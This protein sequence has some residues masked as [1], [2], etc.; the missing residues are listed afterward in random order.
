M[1]SVTEQAALD[2]FLST[3]ELA[4]TD[5]T[6]EKLNNV[7]IIHP[8]QRNP[9]LLSAEEER[10][11]TSKHAANRNRLTVPRRPAWHDGMKKEELDSREKAA[12]LDWRRGLAELQERNEILM[13]PF[14]RNLE[15]WRQLWRVVERSDVVVQIVDA[16]NPLLFRSEDLERY[17]KEVDARKGNMLLVNKADMMSRNQRK[18]WAEYFQAHD[19]AYRFFS[20][21]PKDVEVGLRDSVDEAD[22][23]QASGSAEDHSR[24]TAKDGS[25]YTPE[26][27]ASTGDANDDE[28]QD[29]ST[30]IL[31]PEEL[32]DAFLTYAPTAEGSEFLRSTGSVLTLQQQMPRMHDL[33]RSVL[34]GTPTSENPPPSTPCSERKRCPCRPRLARRSTF[35]PSISAPRSYYVTVRVSSFPIS[36]PRRPNWCVTVSCR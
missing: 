4:G 28:D 23:Q 2:E 10:T 27:Q 5:F 21:S 34:S 32:E 29:E 12:F 26:G 19:V 3:A 17:V 11:A 13:T 25:P 16:R 14:E 22:Q 30:R 35:K 18:A 6:A 31:T 9:Y 15:V 24:P 20:A 1:R 36:P 8:D 7:K 33:F